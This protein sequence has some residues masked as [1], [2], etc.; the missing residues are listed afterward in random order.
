MQALGGCELIVERGPEWLFIRP[1]GASLRGHELDLADQIWSLLEQSMTYR[2]V[3]EL[4]D[5]DLLSSDIISQLVMLQQRICNHGGL[6]RLCG[7]SPTN[8]WA[9][10]SCRL[11]GYLPQYANRTQAVMG[12]RRVKPR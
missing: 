12:E 11:S 7:V 6:M 4:D 5:I 1:D 2:L 9:I 3:L 10:E 8:R